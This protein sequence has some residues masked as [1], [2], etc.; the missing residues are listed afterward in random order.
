MVLSSTG[1]RIAPMP[2]EV[3]ADDYHVQGR[4]V[5]DRPSAA[6]R[7]ASAVQALLII[8][9]AALVLAIVWLLGVAFN[10]F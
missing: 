2:Q 3:P 4:E 8:V 1:G 5:D 6:V 9:M 10:I 7:V